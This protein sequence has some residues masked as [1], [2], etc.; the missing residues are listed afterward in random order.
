MTKKGNIYSMTSYWTVE[1]VKRSSVVLTDIRGNKAEASFD[2]LKEAFVSGDDFSSEEK[3]TK[4]DLNNLI[5]ATKNTA[6]TINYNKIGQ[7]KT[8]KAFKVEKEAKVLEIKNARVS[9]VDRLLNDL[10]ENPI[11]RTIPGENRTIRGYHQGVM[12]SNGY[13][14]FID[15]ESTDK[16]G[17]YVPKQVNI[18]EIQYAI[19]NNVKYTIK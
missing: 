2:A 4:T 10:I 17:L 14:E 11:T 16:T 18:R 5:I 8:D 9:D 7:N 19:L 15:M 13:L 1:E 3:I 12:N 6:M